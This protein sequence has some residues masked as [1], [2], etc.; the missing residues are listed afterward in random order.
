[1]SAN[2][3]QD[4]QS[5]IRVIN[6]NPQELQVY[7]DVVN[8]APRGEQ[9]NAQFLPVLDGEAQ[10]N[11]IAEWIELSETELLIPPEQTVQVPFTVHVP[12]D[13]EPGGHFAAILVGTKPPKGDN[14]SNKVETSQIITSLMLLRVSGDVE[15]SGIIRSFRPTEYLFDKPQVEFELRFQNTGNVHLLPQGEIRITNMWGQE[16][17]VIPIN[18]E[19]LFGNVLPDSVRK[20][21]FTW[22]GQ[23][24]IG[25]IGRYSA[26][27][28]LAYGQEGR[29]FASAETNFWVVPLKALMIVLLIVT[30]FIVIVTWS[31]KA[32]VRKMLSMAGVAPEGRVR[33]IQGSPRK[34][35]VVAPIEAG[36]LDLSD[37][38]KTSDSL[39][40]KLT[41]VREFVRVNRTF[42]VAGTLMVIGVVLIVWFVLLAST[43]ER[44][45][46]V[47]IGTGEH[48]VTITSEDVEYEALR[49]SAPAPLG[50]ATTTSDSLPT[51]RIVNQ[52]SIPG[53]A[54]SLRVELEAAGYTIADLST[55]LNADK[56][57]TVIVY[58]PEYA[59]EALALSQLINGALLSAFAEASDADVPITVYVGRDFENEVQ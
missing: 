32:Y 16:R 13:A 1:M 43:Q 55:D 23:W 41:S 6:S 57:N 54:A 53:L 4:W 8:F 25:D 42:F 49:D 10:G 51:L 21:D 39:S 11:T 47:T 3:S 19:T 12:E 52:S 36:I 9:G 56:N 29:K 17:G 46:E 28:T 2:P 15:E 37:R 27:A 59:E 7:L 50:N 48:P 18:R 44:S 45:Y 20:F 31:I 24:S 40:D 26:V 38:L 22:T 35:S 30:A 5:S 33:R 14:R 34:V 58:A